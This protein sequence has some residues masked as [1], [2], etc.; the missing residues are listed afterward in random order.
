MGNNLTAAQERHR[1]QM[2]E[3]RHQDF[4]AWRDHPIT[5]LVM[6]WAHLRRESLKEAWADGTLTGAFTT[7]MIVKNA[8]AT[9][10]CSI[11][12]DLLAID[13]AELEAMDHE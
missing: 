2:E 4:K 7:E 1:N 8:G 11:L 12:S 13:Y 6:E 9:G 10:A 3:V 5:V